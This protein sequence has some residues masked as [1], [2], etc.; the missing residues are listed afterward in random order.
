MS[1]PIEIFC[2]AAESDQSFL[3]QL[4]TQLALQQQ[5]GIIKLWNKSQIPAGAIADKESQPGQNPML[6][7]Y[8]ANEHFPA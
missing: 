7:Q 5:Q 2:C 8:P 1:Q 3:G 6:A 4:S